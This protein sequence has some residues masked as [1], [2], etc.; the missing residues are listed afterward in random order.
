MKDRLKELT[1]WFD[2]RALRERLLIAACVAAVLA[3]LYSFFFIEPLLAAKTRMEREIGQTRTAL[4]TI[5]SLA[6]S[7]AV[8]IDPAARRRS[9]RDSLRVQVANLD[10][11]M[12]G[13][14]KSLVPPQEVARLLEGLLPRYRNLQ[15]VSLHNLPV[16]RL[17]AGGS[18]PAAKAP[19]SRAGN[20]QQDAKTAA[21]PGERAIYQHSFEIVLQGSYSDLHDYLAQLEKLPWQMFWGSVT[22]DAAGYPQLTATVIVHTLSLDKT[23]LIV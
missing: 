4:Q 14:Q 11:E 20:P 1:D 9:Y 21:P 13:L 6:K 12:Q 19:D 16:K 10:Q 8:Q 3:Y 17:G 7:T 15:L 5:E 18:P 22:V 23:W 2:A